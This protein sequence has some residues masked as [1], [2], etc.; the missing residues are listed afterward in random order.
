MDGS[1]NGNS[2]SDIVR[3]QPDATG[4]VIETVYGKIA[5]IFA[6]YGTKERVMI[7]YA[8]DPALGLEQR[9]ALASL[10]PIRGEINGLVDGWR[11]SRKPK[12]QCR[13]RMFDRRTADALT[14]AL[15][16]DQVHAEELLKAVKADVLEERTSMGRTEYLLFATV[17]AL[18]VF[19]LFGAFT[20]A[21]Q[22]SLN[23]LSIGEFIVDNQ[24]WLA[25]GMGCLGAL[26]SIAMG[27]RGRDIRTDLQRRDNIV[28]AILRIMIGAVSAIVLF[29]LLK[30]GLVRIGGLGDF[31]GAA[32]AFAVDAAI[33]VAFLAGFSE[34][35]V[36]DYLAR[37]TLTSGAD[38]AAA[39][40]SPAL[41]SA[42]RPEVEATER[43]PR[44][45]LEVDI[46]NRAAAA[47][48]GS[49]E[50][51]VHEDDDEDG[52]LCG[53]KIDEDETTDDTELPEATGGV[54][55]RAA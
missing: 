35:L 29:S 28:D 53:V 20:F 45:K 2:V 13:A 6:V 36:G 38:A 21:T 55:R 44:G 16:G 1:S 46:V 47:A 50:V 25:T 26:F 23:T 15:Q 43:N 9:R 52:C 5:D 24:L 40:P 32:T 18:S 27:I 51:H 37:A 34:R 48:G 19:L 30:S 8:D 11:T 33:I 42:A 3:N 54:E 10:N 7:Q 31:E 14:V 12:N 49:P 41:Q 22:Q 17:C 39:T 4:T